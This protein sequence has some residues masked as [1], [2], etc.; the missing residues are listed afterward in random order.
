MGGVTISAKERGKTITTT[1]FTD[2]NGAYVFPALPEGQYR[3][4]A[5]A[6]GFATAKAEIALGAVKQQNFALANLLIVAFQDIEYFLFFSLNGIVRFLEL[7]LK[8][9]DLREV[10]TILAQRI[11]VLRRYFGSFLE[12]IHQ[13]RVALYLG[14]G[15]EIAGLEPVDS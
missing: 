15:I 14:H 8:P 12:Q 9:L 7:R 6:I 4:W 13:R 2:H 11:G 3:L 10:R 1:V 5:Q